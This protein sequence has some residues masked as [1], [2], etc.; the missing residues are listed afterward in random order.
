M[1]VLIVLC[2]FFL[3]PSKLS[4][5]LLMIFIVQFRVTTFLSTSSTD[6]CRYILLLAK[7]IIWD[8]TNDVSSFIPILSPLSYFDELIAPLMKNN[9][10]KLE[11]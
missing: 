6:L 4:H 2:L 1:I 3:I 5:S 7:P 10:I 8:T 9:I 11:K